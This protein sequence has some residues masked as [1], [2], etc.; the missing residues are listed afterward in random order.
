MAN[1]ITGIG[2]APATPYAIHVTWLANPIQKNKFRE[3]L[4]A[5]KISSE[6]RHAVNMTHS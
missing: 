2:P 6:S 4:T 3:L 5:H 1:S